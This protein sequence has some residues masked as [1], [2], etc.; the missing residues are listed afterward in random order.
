[1]K[2]IKQAHPELYRLDRLDA[3]AEK[4]SQSGKVA[5]QSASAVTKVGS[6]A[7]GFVG[8]VVVS[9]LGVVAGVVASGRDRVNT[10]RHGTVSPDGKIQLEGSRLEKAAAVIGG[11]MATGFAAALVYDTAFFL[12]DSAWISPFAAA[13]V[14][15]GIGALALGAELAVRGAWRGIVDSTKAAFGLARLGGKKVED[16]LSRLFGGKKDKADKTEKLETAEKAPALPAPKP[17]RART[18]RQA[19]T[20]KAA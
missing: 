18:T 10:Q 11:A 12:F 5:M 16:T 9:P 2:V 17:T 6:A 20:D 7:L 3:R 4:L 1:M 19:K 14:A 8:S 13:G 15:G